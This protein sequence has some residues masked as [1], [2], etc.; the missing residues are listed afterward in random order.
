LVFE[1]KVLLVVVG[2][3][4]ETTN[5]FENNQKVGCLEDI[6]PNKEKKH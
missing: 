2:T 4:D 3:I 1:R 5:Y 6:Y